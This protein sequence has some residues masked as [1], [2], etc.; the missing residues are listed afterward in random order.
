[1]VT[2][3]KIN[4]KMKHL[5]KFENYQNDELEPI[6]VSDFPPEGTYGLKNV[7][8]PLETDMIED[9]NNDKQIIKFVAEKRVFLQEETYDE[10]SIWC[11]EG[12]E[13][14]E[15]YIINNYS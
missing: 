15:R 14:V 8:N 12:D 1:M 13:E 7:F 11:A 9:W 5:K 6:G 10:W 4:R 2:K 3:N